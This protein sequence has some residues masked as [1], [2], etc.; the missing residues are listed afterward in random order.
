MTIKKNGKKYYK[1]NELTVSAKITSKDVAEF[2]V[3]KKLKNEGITGKD[4][5]MCGLKTYIE[6][7]KSTERFKLESQIKLIESRMYERELDM[8]ADGL[9]LEKLYSDL[10][11]VMV[12]SKE[13]EEKLISAIEKEFYEFMDDERY[14]EETR[15]DIGR[16]YDIRKDAIDIQAYYAGVSYEQAIE[17]F[18]DYLDMLNDCSVLD[19]DCVFSE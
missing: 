1:S 17:I 7:I 11:K 16:F 5:F 15:S 12:L 3:L 6:R 14:S 2:S 8:V 18:D 13:K 9:L 10:D 19:D 4:V